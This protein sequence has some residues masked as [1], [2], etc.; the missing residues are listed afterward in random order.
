MSHSGVA[1]QLV[2]I[3]TGTATISRSFVQ[4]AAES[5]TADNCDNISGPTE[6]GTIVAFI[7]DTGDTITF[8]HNAPG[9]LR[10][11]SGTDF[12]LSGNDTF[13]LLFDGSNYREIVR[14]NNS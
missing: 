12:A 7:A 3:A 10:L 11:E 5:G 2:T 14:R 6:A 8:R 1:A 4:I 13:L 9:N